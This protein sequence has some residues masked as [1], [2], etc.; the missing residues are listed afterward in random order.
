[1]NWIRQILLI[2]V[3]TMIFSAIMLEGLLRAFGYVPYFLNRHAFIPSY[4]Q[5]TVYTLKP[6][7]RGYYAGNIISVNSQGFRGDEID[8]NDTS[9][10]R[11]AII[12]DSVAFGQGVAEDETL[13]ELLE[14]RLQD[15]T[16]DRVEVVNLGVPGYDTCQEL[17][18]FEQN[19]ERIKPQVAVLVYYLND[20]EESLITVKDGIVISSDIRTGLIGNIMAAARKSSY[21]YNLIWTNWQ[22]IKHRLSGSADYKT[23]VA[24][25]F[26]D[27]YR[28]WQRSRE[29]LAA[30]ASLTKL[31]SIRLVV[32]P[33][34]PMSAL[35]EKPYPFSHYISSICEEALINNV[36]CLDIVPAIRDRSL[37]LIISHIETHPSPDVYARVAEQIEEVLF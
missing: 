15:K 17:Q 10:L 35:R 37:R 14:T 30:L 6:G 25:R 4:D 20:T 13:S 32:I 28:G 3:P 21:A 29:C 19:M 27:D 24:R 33:F 34:P 1:M 12:G 2:T 8:Q 23:V 16:G 31:Q 11:I 26:N 9:A 5:A 7:F 22:V 18:R 36:E